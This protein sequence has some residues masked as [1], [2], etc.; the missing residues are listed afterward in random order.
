MRIT[1][2]ILLPVCVFLF[3]KICK[4]TVNKPI[5]TQKHLQ[6]LN[7]RNSLRYFFFKSTTRLIVDL[8][9]LNLVFENFL[10]IF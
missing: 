1:T 10:V 6:N 4:F 8:S 2:I 3:S 5:S 7:F 9:K